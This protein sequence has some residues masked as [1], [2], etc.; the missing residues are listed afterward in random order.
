M[1][2]KSLTEKK[3]LPE[4]LGNVSQH[5]VRALKPMLLRGLSFA[6]EEYSADNKSTEAY[7]KRS[8]LLLLLT[9]TFGAYGVCISL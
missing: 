9:P 3:C 2:T 5:F 1:A 6:S 4:P 8:K 7:F